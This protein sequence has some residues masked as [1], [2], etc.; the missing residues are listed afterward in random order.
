MLLLLLLLLQLLLLRRLLL[1]LRRLKGGGRRNPQRER[2]S[3]LTPILVI[4]PALAAR[5]AV[6]AFGDELMD[7]K[8]PDDPD[9]RWVSQ[10]GCRA[11]ELQ[12]LANAVCS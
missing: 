11:P 2:I 12:R 8:L 7:L 4:P 10:D 3:A 6:L 9:S 1:L 5:A